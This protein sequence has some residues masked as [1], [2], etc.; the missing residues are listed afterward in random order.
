MT[1]PNPSDPEQVAAVVG[2]VVRPWTVTVAGYGHGDYM[3]SSRGKALA[4]A[5]RSSAFEGWSFGEFLKRATCHLNRAPWER[6]GERITVAGRPAYL[7]GAN[8]QYV[9]FVRPGEDIVFNAHPFDVQDGNGAD[10]PYWAKR[11]AHLLAETAA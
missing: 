10:W 5:W 3:A 1:P 6:F 4:Q 9:Q 11:P 8:K 2:M 7:I